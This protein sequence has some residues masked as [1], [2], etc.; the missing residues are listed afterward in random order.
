MRGVP[1]GTVVPLLCR[2]LASA[3]FGSHILTCVPVRAA[4]LALRQLLLQRI[5]DA[6][7]DPPEPLDARIARV[8]AAMQAAPEKTWT[9]S[10]MAQ[11]AHLSVSQFRRLFRTATGVTPNIYLA[12]ERVSRART[13]LIESNLTLEAIADTL[14]YSDVYYFSRQFKCHAGAPPAR[15]RRAGRYEGV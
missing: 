11:V 10:S 9:L 5:R 7:N 3:S 2:K 6:H 14:G 13:L 12:R 15:Y 4:E 8:L 1:Q